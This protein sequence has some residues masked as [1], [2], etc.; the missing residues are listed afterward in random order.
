MRTEVRVHDA[1]PELILDNNMLTEILE[2]LKQE[3]MIQPKKLTEYILDKIDNE[4]RN[5]TI[6][7]NS[8]YTSVSVKIPI[9]DKINLI[10]EHKD[11]IEHLIASYRGFEC[12]MILHNVGNDD[13][14]TVIL[15]PK[16]KL[17]P[18]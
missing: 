13:S 4:L 16:G 15:S 6:V 14:I 17:T 11:T 1:T 8:D 12:A 2:K 10:L 3:T 9:D 18:K 5:G 7:S